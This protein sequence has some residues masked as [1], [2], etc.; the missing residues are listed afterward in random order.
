MAAFG[1]TTATFKIGLDSRGHVTGFH[2]VAI[3]ETP[4]PKSSPAPRQE[5]QLDFDRQSGSTARPPTDERV[6]EAGP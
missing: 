5:P 2:I 1:Q 3:G 4:G 6:A